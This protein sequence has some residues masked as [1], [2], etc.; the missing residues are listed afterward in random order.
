[1]TKKCR[2]D[3]DITTPKLNGAWQQG[4][5]ELF[6]LVKRTSKLWVNRFR[7][8]IA[9]HVHAPGN[10]RLF[11]QAD[12]RVQISRTAMVQTHQPGQTAF[13]SVLPEDI[14]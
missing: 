2:T 1:V 6:Y 8:S 4:R 7:G 5:K 14:E 13:R 10:R 3:W 9:I 12:Q 11:G